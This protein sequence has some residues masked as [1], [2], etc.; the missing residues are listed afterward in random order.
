MDALVTKRAAK[1]RLQNL[2]HTVEYKI[3]NLLWRIDDPEGVCPLN[4]EA[5]EELFIDSVEELLLLRELGNSVSGI[6]YGEVEA[7]ELLEEIV[8]GEV[9]AGECSDNFLNFDRNV[10]ALHKVA[11]IEN[12]PEDALGEQVLDKHLLNSVLAKVRIE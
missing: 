6:L 10:V 3:D 9:T 8:T 7:I 1:F 11:H 2:L 4:S 5:L 12:F